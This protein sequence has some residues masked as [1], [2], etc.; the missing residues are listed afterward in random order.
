MTTIMVPDDVAVFLGQPKEITAYVHCQGL[1][2]IVHTKGIKG[3]PPGKLDYRVR[4]RIK[5]S[6]EIAARAWRLCQ[7][8]PLRWAPSQ[9]RVRSMRQ[10]LFEC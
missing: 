5:P 10:S 8:L 4:A 7:R 3:R 2:D 9:A 6:L 1:S